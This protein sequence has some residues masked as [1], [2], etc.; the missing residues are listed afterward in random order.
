M[1]GSASVLIDCVTWSSATDA[2]GMTTCADTVV[3]VLGLWALFNAMLLI[4]NVLAL[5]TFVR[6]STI[7]GFLALLVA[8]GTGHIVHFVKA[9]KGNGIS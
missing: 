9:K 3:V 2:S 8:N 1:T 5:V 7:T 4:Q 6:A